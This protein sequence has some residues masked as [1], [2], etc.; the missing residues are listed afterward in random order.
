MRKKKQT[1]TQAERFKRLETLDLSERNRYRERQRE[2][3]T[4]REGAYYGAEDKPMISAHT[5][6]L[7]LQS[8]TW[9]DASKSDAA[10][11]AKQTIGGVR[12]ALPLLSSV[13]S[14]RA[15]AFFLLPGP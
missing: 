3:E 4:E 5:V 12:C 11:A 10:T 14:S 13:S 9:L 1:R 6:P 2:R 8:G 15:L 7:K